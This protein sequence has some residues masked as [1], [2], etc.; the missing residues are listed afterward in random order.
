[1]FKYAI[2][3]IG[4]EKPYYDQSI[5]ELLSRHGKRHDCSVNFEVT[6]SF[7]QKR[8]RFKAENL[9]NLVRLKHLKL[10]EIHLVWCAI[11]QRLTI[12]KRS[13]EWT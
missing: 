11:V 8:M 1:M 12:P 3:K 7:G 4:L 13:K 9:G 6:P 10:L 5:L 2:G